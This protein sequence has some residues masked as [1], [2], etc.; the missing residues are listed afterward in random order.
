MSHIVIRS[1]ISDITKP[2][3]RE[4]DIVRYVKNLL[5]ELRAYPKIQ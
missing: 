1:T 4:S 2:D 5:D 3:L